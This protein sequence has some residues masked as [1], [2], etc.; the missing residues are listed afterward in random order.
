M[1]P[2]QQAE[3]MV[4]ALLRPLSWLGYGQG[5]DSM[6][7]AEGAWRSPG[8]PSERVG[9]QGA[10]PFSLIL[11]AYPP[12]CSPFCHSS[13]PPHLLTHSPTPWCHREPP[14][15]LMGFVPCAQQDAAEGVSMATGTSYLGC[16]ML[17]LRIFSLLFLC[18]LYKTWH[19]LFS[20][21]P[22][23]QNVFQAVLGPVG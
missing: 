14:K 18:S 20:E 12:P 11:A 23:D 16:Q 17:G 2:R 10:R 13:S 7:V 9:V 21:W 15:S 6:T 4:P 1:H 3:D 19:I 5:L 22:D 8:C